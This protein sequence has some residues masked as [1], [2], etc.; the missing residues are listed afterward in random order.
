VAEVQGPQTALG[1]LNQLG[2]EGPDVSRYHLY[3]AIRAD[4]LRRLGRPA[5]A[6]A[7]YETAIDLAAN[8]AE[9]AFLR[10]R[11]E[12]LPNAGGAASDAGG[13]ASDA[14]G[15]ASDAGPVSPG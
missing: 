12:S 9:R 10:R 4:L 15:A 2:T 6:T 7:A 8:E 14:G 1:L 3:H 13:A 11:L 5:D